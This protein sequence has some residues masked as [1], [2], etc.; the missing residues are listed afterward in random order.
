[1]EY[2]NTD[3][4]TGV[5]LPDGR[6]ATLSSDLE[7]SAADLDRLIPGDGRA[8]ADLMGDFGKYAHRV[9]SAIQSRFGFEP[10]VKR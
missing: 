10:R 2:V 4:P 1:L 3:F 8:L 6:S 7:T 5:V 9:F